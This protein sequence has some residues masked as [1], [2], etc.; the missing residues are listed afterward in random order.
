[1]SPRDGVTSGR[2]AAIQLLYDDHAQVLRLLDA[3]DVLAERGRDGDASILADAKRSLE[4]LRRFG[5]DAHHGK[6]ELHLFPALVRAGLPRRGGPVA[7]MLAEHD[8]GRE[9]VR[10]MHDGLAET[11]AG[12]PGGPRRFAEAA[13]D[14]S[15]L[16]RDH[17]TKEDEVLFPMSDEVVP[18]D[19]LATLVARFA[20]VDAATLGPGGRAAAIE[21]IAALV[22]SAARP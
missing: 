1:M 7:C 11:Q 3:L 12:S 16:Y 10:R 18:V 9:H 22:R 6:E 4:L 20:D 15:R 19:V 2:S 21:A 14:Y 5:D 17:I 13:G 8:V